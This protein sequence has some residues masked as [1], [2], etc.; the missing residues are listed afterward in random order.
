M[1]GFLELDK[2][3]IRWFLS[4]DRRD[5]PA[6]A[7]TENATTF[8]ALSVDGDEF[9]FSG[10]FTDLHTLVYRDIL[11]GK[12]YGLEDARAAINLVYELR[13]A[14]ATPCTGTHA[15]PLLAES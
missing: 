15:H 13:N 11:A 7:E 2:A 5:L 3:N 12:G 1:S 6:I 10:G 14:K 4:V 8:R 9:E